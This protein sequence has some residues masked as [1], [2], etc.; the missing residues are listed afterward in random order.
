MTVQFFC[1]LWLQM[2]FCSMH[3]ACK[4]ET[5]HFFRGRG[6]RWGGDAG[7]IREAPF[8]NC[9]TPRQLAIFLHGPPWRG[10]F[11]G[12]PPPKKKKNSIIIILTLSQDFTFFDILCYSLLHVIVLSTCMNTIFTISNTNTESCLSES[13]NQKKGKSVSDLLVIA[14]PERVAF[15]IFFIWIAN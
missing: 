8:K 2:K 12:W 4:Y 9:M 13:T 7:G 10:N 3:Q 11:F 14:R 5:V 6:K 15:G 1:I